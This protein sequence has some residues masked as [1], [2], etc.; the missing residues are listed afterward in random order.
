MMRGHKPGG[1]IHNNI[2]PGGAK[3]NNIWVLGRTLNAPTRV[4]QGADVRRRG[5]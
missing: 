4:I 5:S 3:T 2:L 1:Y